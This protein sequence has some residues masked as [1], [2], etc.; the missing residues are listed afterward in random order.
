MPSP[1]GNAGRPTPHPTS[2]SNKPSSGPKK[3]RGRSAEWEVK[4]PLTS[5]MLDSTN[6]PERLAAFKSKRQAGSTKMGTM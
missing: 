4:H 5:E 2:R 3:Y 1:A 6:V